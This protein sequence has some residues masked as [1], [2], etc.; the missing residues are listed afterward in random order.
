[1]IA[2]AVE[3]YTLEK[4]TRR[5]PR[6]RSMDVALGLKRR[7]G[8]QR[9]RRGVACEPQSTFTTFCSGAKLGWGLLI[10]IRRTFV[11]F[12]GFMRRTRMEL[13]STFLAT[14]SCR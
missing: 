14:A 5:K 1:M 7:P 4:P 8:R 3:A 2:D 6:A 12:S 13:L 9:A 10:A 11:R